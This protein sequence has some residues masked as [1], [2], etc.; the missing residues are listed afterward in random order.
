MDELQEQINELKAQVQKLESQQLRFPL[1]TVSNDIIKN[2][3]LMFE[4]ED[5]SGTITADKNLTISINGKL[6]QINAL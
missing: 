6:Y 2:N 3:K 5:T 1:D 4:R